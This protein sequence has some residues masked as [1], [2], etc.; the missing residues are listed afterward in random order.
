MPDPSDKERDLFLDAMEIESSSKRKLFLEKACCEDQDLLDRLSQLLKLHEEAGDFLKGKGKEGAQSTEVSEPQTRIVKPDSEELGTVI[1][2]YKLLQQI[3]EGGFGIVYMAE[4]REPIRRKIALKI[5]KLGMDT[6]QVVA[7]FEAER[8][9]LA[10]MDHTNIAKVLDGG[11][12]DTG[13]PYFV[14][15]L[16]RGVPVIEFCDENKLSTEDRL[17]LFIEVCQA[18]HHAHQKGVIHRDIKPSNILVTMHNDRAVPKVIDF[19]IAKATQHELTEKTVFT[20]YNEFMGTPAYMS[21]EQA[22]FSGLDIDTRTD[23]YSLGVLLCELLT[24]R[25]PFDSK[26][27]LNEG[28]DSLRKIIRE[29]DPPKP[30]TQL[31]TFSSDELK[32]AAE[33]RQ[34]DPGRLWHTV[35]GDLDW[36]VLKSLE[37]DRSR[38]YE[39]ALALAGDVQNFL[40]DEPVSAV[41]PSVGYR[42]R[43][44]ARRNRKTLVASIAVMASLIGGTVVSSVMAY[45]AIH[46]EHTV[47][48]LLDK[49]FD[50]RKKS[51]EAERDAREAQE[52]AKNEAAVAAAVNRF[53]NEDLIG[54]ANPINEP[55]RD[56]RL[57]TLLDRASSRI[58][59]RFVDQPVAEAAIRQTLSQAYLN[60]GSFTVAEKHARRAVQ[61]RRSVLKS[62]DASLFQSRILLAATLVQEGRYRETVAELEVLLAETTGLFSRHNELTIETA[63][64]LSKTYGQISRA[65]E[66]EQLMI[67]FLPTAEEAL[68]DDHW[69]RPTIVNERCYYHV[70]YRRMDQAEA[71]A[72]RWLARYRSKF[73]REHPFSIMLMHHLATSL[74]SQ[75]KY[76]EAR[77]VYE[78]ALSLQESVL[79]YDHPSRIKM[80]AE[81]SWYYRFTGKIGPAEKLLVEAFELGKQVLGASHPDTRK[82]SS[83]LSGIYSSEDRRPKRRAFLHQVLSDD[84]ENPH[85]LEHLAGFLDIE[86]LQSIMPSG[87]RADSEWRFTLVEPGEGWDG[88]EFDD[89][90]WSLG[91]APFGNAAD[92]GYKTKWDGRTIW[93]R[94]RFELSEI[95]SGRLVLRVLQDDHSEIYLNEKTALRRQSWTGRRRLLIYASDDA[96][97]GLKVG[98][99]VIAIRCDNI[100]LEGFI[101]VGLYVET[102]VAGDGNPVAP[103]R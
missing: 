49:E 39:S 15:E 79:G 56:L 16:V 28:Y 77:E 55:D 70:A 36:I 66:G 93:L 96:M 10:M 44:F 40:D 82:I 23:I 61:L 69:L 94:R 60:L 48:E 31:S 22:Q 20:R 99:N 4:Q 14:M 72:Q 91:M 27:L 74:L 88:E 63:Y 9:A 81:F 37:K 34:S 13:R 30:S 53:L 67:D 62:T 43:K 58:E 65:D 18:I 71:F 33:K 24:G 3:G 100:D 64:W 59:E 38:R 86:T 97:R 46:A 42:F 73:G 76:E 51:Q 75:G 54:Y 50:A 90:N 32:M 80:M 45:R 52:L 2:R 68:P 26:E 35:R 98:E 12:T 25:T 92:P 84:P 87:D 29:K 101:D 102:I 5:I 1:G 78:E 8:Q 89:S 57:S 21:P 85:A 6:K 17:R 83:W 47:R 41:A 95:P 103:I 7:R 19:G 11:A